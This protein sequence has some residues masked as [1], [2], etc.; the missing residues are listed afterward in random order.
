[1]ESSVLRRGKKR[2]DHLFQEV[3]EE[4]RQPLPTEGK[5]QVFVA[6]GRQRS[7]S[8]VGEV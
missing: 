8:R 3:E 5:R 7:T 2:E 1:M 4:S 6:P